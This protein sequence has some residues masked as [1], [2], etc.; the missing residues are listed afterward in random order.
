LNWGGLLQITLLS[1]KNNLKMMKIINQISMMKPLK[2]G[3]QFFF[4]FL[5]VNF[6]NPIIYAMSFLRV[7]K[8]LLA[9]NNPSP[10]DG[11]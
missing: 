2:I 6:I 11:Y 10:F 1:P 4:F 9:M 7:K 5:H 3:A 8:V